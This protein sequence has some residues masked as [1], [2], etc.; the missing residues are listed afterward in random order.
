MGAGRIVYELGGSLWLLDVNSKQT[1]QIP[2]EIR[3]DAPEVRPY[4]KKV[5]EEVTGFECSVNYVGA[6]LGAIYGKIKL[7]PC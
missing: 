4:M 7:A 3:T 2:V 6:K 1:G 5:D